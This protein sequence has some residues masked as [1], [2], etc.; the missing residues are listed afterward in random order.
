MMGISAA[1]RGEAPHVRL[2]V[3]S[4]FQCHQSQKTGDFKRVPF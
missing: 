1:F 2:L 4:S 3:K